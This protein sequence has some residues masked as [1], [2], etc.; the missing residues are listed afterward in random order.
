MMVSQV[1]SGSIRVRW[2]TELCSVIT[3]PFQLHNNTS[4]TKKYMGRRNVF[5]D[6]LFIVRLQIRGIAYTARAPARGAPH[7]WGHCCAEI[8]YF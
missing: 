7:A 3:S 5:A 6:H 8:L 2:L 1:V 4:N